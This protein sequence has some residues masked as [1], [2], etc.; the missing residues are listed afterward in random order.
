MMT[1]YFYIGIT[2]AIVLAVLLVWY[3]YAGMHTVPP[4]KKEKK[5]K[6]A[7]IEECPPALEECKAD[8]FEECAPSKDT[9]PKRKPFDYLR[10]SIS[11]ITDDIFLADCSMSFNHAKLEELGITQFILVGDAL[12]PHDEDRYKILHVK[13][14]DSYDANIQPYFKECVEFI[15]N[16][17]TLV[18]C[19]NGSSRS[20]AIVVSCIMQKNKMKMKDAIEMVKQIR[21]IVNIEDHFLKQLI[22]LEGKIFSQ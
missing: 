9:A 6:I 19:A 13:V 14:D 5:K 10:P 2:I 18:Y 4:K 15:S 3:L 11:Q 1:Y 12:R 7:V 8:V 16:G 22:T 17:K 20:A 21:P